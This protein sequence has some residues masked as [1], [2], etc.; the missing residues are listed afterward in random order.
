MCTFKLSDPRLPAELW[1]ALESDND[2]DG[3]V[4]DEHH[5]IDDWSGYACAR[6]QFQNLL[7]SHITTVSQ[8]LIQPQ[9][10]RLAFHKWVRACRMNNAWSDGSIL[11]PKQTL[12]K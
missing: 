6:E 4:E 12:N 3:P 11:G 7:Q 10:D 8:L 2:S 9:H 1:D 5:A